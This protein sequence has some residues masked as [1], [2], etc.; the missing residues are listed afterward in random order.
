[1]R[2]K[3]RYCTVKDYETGEKIY[4]EG[5]Q[6]NKLWVGRKG[7]KSRLLQDIKEGKWRTREY[8]YNT[9]EPP[10]GQKGNW[11]KSGEFAALVEGNKKDEA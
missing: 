9:E 8:C 7:G 5:K 2:N 6:D 3:Y 4:L 10:K 1:M 11:I